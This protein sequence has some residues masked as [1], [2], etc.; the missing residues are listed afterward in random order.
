MTQQLS[1]SKETL[2][3]LDARE[4]QDVVGGRFPV[5]R[6]T[7]CDCGGGESPTQFGVC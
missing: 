5:T 1:L 7:Q 6:A 2:R 3:A 4:Q